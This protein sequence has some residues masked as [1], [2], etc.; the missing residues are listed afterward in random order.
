MKKATSSSKANKMRRQL[1]TILEKQASS[2]SSNHFSSVYNSQTPAK[3][4]LSNIL[5]RSEMLR[6]DSV[7]SGSSSKPAALSMKR[8]Q[9]LHAGSTEVV[10]RKITMTKAR[11]HQT[12][13]MKQMT[14]APMARSKL[15]DC[16]EDELESS[17]SSVEEDA[18][19]EEEEIKKLASEFKQ[20]KQK[21]PVTSKP[22]MFK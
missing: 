21:P 10:E 15:A 17:N 20:A 5:T 8:T 9:T 14:M 13:A 12:A 6:S 11:S 18:V 3:R 22:N 2:V 16:L 19:D 7:R 1:S 4:Q